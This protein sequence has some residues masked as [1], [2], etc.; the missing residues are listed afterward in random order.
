MTAGRSASSALASIFPPGVA[1]AVGCSD[2]PEEGGYAAE[3]ALVERAVETRRREFVSGR[4]CA[5]RAL[6]QLGC[7]PT[8]ILVGTHRE[9]LWPEGMVGS[10][11]HD[12][13]FRAAAVGR[14]RDFASIGVDVEP[15]ETLPADV[16][17]QVTT[18]PERAMLSALPPGVAWDR[19]L[20]SGKESIFKAWFPLAR[21]WLDFTDCELTLRPT[22]FVGRLLVP[23]PRLG[24]RHLTQFTGRWTVQEEHLFTAVT[25]RAHR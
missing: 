14:T 8:A 19:V 20:F 18:A 7:A 3:L 2:D 25:L 12:D 23:G 4:A 6:R 9:P 5:R 22:T 17:E 13:R 1:V 24:T 21:T 10:L 16:L 15:D 11:T